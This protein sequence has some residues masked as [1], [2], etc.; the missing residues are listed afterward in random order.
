M[1]RRIHYATF[2]QHNGN[3][4]AV[5]NPTYDVA[6]DW[7]GVV[8]DWPCSMDASSGG[9]TTRGR[10]TAANAVY[11]LEGEYFGAASITPQHRCKLGGETYGIQRVY[12]RDGLNRT[13]VVEISVEY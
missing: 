4:D 10:K 9:E 3:Q 13:L 6:A 5:G 12:S 2:E 8:T 1:S 11:V 7:T